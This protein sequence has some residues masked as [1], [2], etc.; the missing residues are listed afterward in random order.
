MEKRCASPSRKR[1]SRRGI[2]GHGTASSSLPEKSVDVRLCRQESK[3][4]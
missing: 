2:R 1:R 3:E 4:G